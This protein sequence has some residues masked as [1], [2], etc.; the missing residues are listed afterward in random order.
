[1]S[2]WQPIDTAPKD[3]TLVYLKSQKHP[4]VCEIMSWQTQYW[5][6]FK[7][8]LMGSLKTYWDPADPPTHW[9]ALE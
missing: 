1:M 3:G 9:R 7:H 6:G 2:D 5:I 8:T 4:D